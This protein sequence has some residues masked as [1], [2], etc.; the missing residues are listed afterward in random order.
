MSLLQYNVGAKTPGGRGTNRPQLHH[1]I[2]LYRQGYLVHHAYKVCRHCH[3]P[4]ADHLVDL[5]VRLATG[6]VGTDVPEAKTEPKARAPLDFDA[7]F[8]M[9]RAALTTVFK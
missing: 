8:F 6:L 9:S 1:S 2:P 5:L 4:K 3:C 7:I